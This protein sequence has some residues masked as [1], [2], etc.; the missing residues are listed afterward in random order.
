MAEK[1]IKEHYVPQRYLRH[2]ANG[3][4]FFVFDKEKA[5][6]RPGNVSDYA[7]ERFFYDIDF[8][9]L[10]ADFKESNPKCEYDPEMEKLIEE[11]DEQ[12]VEHWFGE[13]VET[14]L[15]DPL[16][17]I[18]VS[19]SMGNPK[20]LEQINVLDNVEMD[21]IS[22]Y[23]AIQMMRT[24][25]MRESISEMYER[26]PLLLMKKKAKTKE[27]KELLDSVKLELKNEDYKKVLQ[28]QFLMDPEIA[29]DIAERLRDKIWMIGYNRTEIPF[30]TSDN[31][32]V[33]YG[34]NG[35]NGLNS[36]GTEICFP[37]SPK[38]ILI[39]KDPEVF[40]YENDLYNHFFEV[41][42]DEVKFYNELQ[43]QQSYRYI[44]EKNGD[45]DLADKIVQ[46]KPFFKD[47]KRNRF[48]ME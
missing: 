37:I 27:E 11:I 40:W 21:F 30:F 3:N 7:C 24:K 4:K 26:L 22:L 29:A 8:N 14:W 34:H 5:Q 39:L 48:F 17:K 1:V 41:H 6:K 13:N 36:K 15:F 46:A 16:D 43:V 20:Y 38:L 12:H 32:V 19:Y 47:I 33:K 18:L 2:F 10:K 42:E 28:S 31:P 25:E 23:L 45:L 35:R 9:K 44:F